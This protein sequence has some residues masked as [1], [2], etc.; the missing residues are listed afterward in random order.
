MSSDANCRWCRL[1]VVLGGGE[2]AFCAPL[3]R[4]QKGKELQ[5]QRW[6]LLITFIEHNDIMD[7]PVDLSDAFKG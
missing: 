5:F 2:G 6:L 1:R 4:Y 7:S 3:S